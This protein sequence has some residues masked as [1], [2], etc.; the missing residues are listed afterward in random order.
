MPKLQ[1]KALQTQWLINGDN[2]KQTRGDKT[3]KQEKIQNN[4]ILLEKYYC[5]YCKTA[6]NEHE[7]ICNYEYNGR[8]ASG[9]IGGDHFYCECGKLLHIDY[10][11]ITKKTDNKL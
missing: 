11:L 1:P 2:N 9:S 8:Y 3:K 10:D 4:D 5:K 7:I 6:I